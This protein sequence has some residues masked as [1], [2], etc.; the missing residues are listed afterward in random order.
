MKTTNLILLSIVALI[1]GIAFFFVCRYTYIYKMTEL[2]QKAKEAFV[3][4]V[5]QELKSRNMKGD[6]SF[7]FNEKSI[8]TEELPDT[9]YLE[10]ESGKYAYRLYPEKNRINIAHDSKT[11]FSHSY[12][13]RTNPLLSDSLNTIWREWLL[14]SNISIQTALCISVNDG[15]GKV[16][17]QSSSHNVWCSPS[18]LILHVTIGYACE[19]EIFGYLHY[20]IWRMMYM[21]ILFYLLLCSLFVYGVYKVCVAARE[22]LLAQQKEKIVE[23]PIIQIVEVPI[24]QIVKEVSGTPLRVYTL[25]E[26]ILFYAEQKML[27]VDG[28]EKPIRSQL[29]QLLEL[30]L[31]AE[32]YILTDEVI[33]KHMWPDGTDSIERVHKVITRLRSFLR[34]NDQSINIAR[35]VGTYQLLL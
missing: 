11:R 32:A 29:C 17:S 9:V 13:F 7:Y 34:E 24:I 6:F 2:N 27:K 35:G 21:E 16:K 26:N 28:L 4:A 3:K 15:K 23:V 19:L 5:N 20:S 31:N 22:K 30:F 25:R 8:L 33:R 14:K 18:N 1:G 10:D 12:A